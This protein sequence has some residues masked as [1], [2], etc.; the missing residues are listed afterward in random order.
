MLDKQTQLAA[1]FVKVSSTAVEILTSDK[2]LTGQTYTLTVSAVTEKGT[3]VHPQDF[4][5]T[6]IDSCTSTILVPHHTTNNLDLSAF[7]G[8]S[9][10]LSYSFKAYTDSVSDSNGRANLC[11]NITYT[12]LDAPSIVTIK[13]LTVSLDTSKVKAAESFSLVLVA[14]LKDY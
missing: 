4:T 14:K 7:A 12:L 9:Q 13:E 6:M 1:P 11:G 8:S 3:K 2:S 10:P 5:V